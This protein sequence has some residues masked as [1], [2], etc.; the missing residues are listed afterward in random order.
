M[1]K[2]SPEW[3][4]FQEKISEHFRSL[5]T[6]SETNVKIEGVRTTHDVDVYVQTKFLGQDMQW[7]VEAKLWKTRVSKSHVLALRAIV[8]DRYG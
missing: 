6:K 4:E 3:Y 2:K 5:G 1:P 8:E 7:I